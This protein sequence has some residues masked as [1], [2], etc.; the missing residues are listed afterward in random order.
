MNRTLNLWAVLFAAL[1]LSACAAVPINPTIHAT[2]AGFG[3]HMDAVDEGGSP[4]GALGLYTATAQVTP[5]ENS[6]GETLEAIWYEG[7][8]ALRDEAGV[9]VMDADGNI[10]WDGGTQIHDGRS[11]CSINT[12]SFLGEFGFGGNGRILHITS[13]GN[14]APEL[15]AKAGEWL[16]AVPPVQETPEG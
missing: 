3:I 7:V 1:V 16:G 6:K 9:L 12:S 10:I 5:N 13:S 8:V 14:G 2:S 4:S 15:C 11:T